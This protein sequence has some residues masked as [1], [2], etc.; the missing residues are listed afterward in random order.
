MNAI[1]RLG[2]SVFVWAGLAALALSHAVAAQG[3]PEQQA[4]PPEQSAT[5]EPQPAPEEQ[6]PAPEPP[7]TPTPEQKAL[8]E[9]MTAIWKDQ[10]IDFFYHSTDAIYACSALES[11]VK[12]IMRAVGAENVKVSA[13]D[14]DQFLFDQEVTGDIFRPSIERDRFGTSAR[15]T[16]RQQNAHVRIDF[17]SP[18]PATPEGL[19]ELNKDK[20]RRELVA[21]VTGNAE[22]LQEAT[23]LFP[24]HWQ[25]V[26]FNRG[27][28]LRLEPEECDLVDQMARSV[29]PRIGV[30]IVSN[31]TLCVPHQVSM[32]QPNLKVAA[33]VKTTFNYG[34]PPP[35]SKKSKKSKKEEAPAPAPP[36]VEPP[37]P[38]AAPPLPESPPEQQ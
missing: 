23:G 26:A 1:R 17:K 2:M 21:R 14:C 4:A 35:K 16:N 7:P 27:D 33:L 15:R 22:A 31:S 37:A 36:P 11:R 25:E 3:T 13:N 18:V 6:S 8:A 32:L 5:P 20:A 28:P 24:A 30:R 9:S 19:A 12:S 10:Q 34:S 38:E 29:L